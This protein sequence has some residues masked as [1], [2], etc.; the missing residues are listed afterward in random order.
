MPR[1]GLWLL[2]YLGFSLVPR[3]DPKKQ[4]E[5][6]SRMQARCR[7]VPW[8]WRSL[9]CPL[10]SFLLSLAGPSAPDVERESSSMLWVLSCECECVFVRWSGRP[11]RIVYV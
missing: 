5:S 8:G 3:N 6:G 10:S 9:R 1:A 2:A 11:S 4:V 7:F